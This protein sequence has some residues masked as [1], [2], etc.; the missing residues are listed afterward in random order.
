MISEKQTT[1]LVKS[2]VTLAITGTV[3]MAA[4]AMSTLKSMSFIGKSDKQVSSISVTGEGSSY[5]IPDM[6]SLSFS[7]KAEAK[8]QKKAADEVNVSMKKMIDALKVA[9][10]SEKDIKTNSYNLY[11]QYDWTQQVCP[12]AEA[13]IAVPCTPGKQ[14]LRG[15]EVNQ[16]VEISIKGKENFDNVANFVDV[17]TKN[18][19]TDIGQLQF[20]VEKPEKIQ[21]E[22]REIAIKQAKLKAE[23]LAEQLG[24]ELT[25][26]VGFYEGG[27]SPEYNGR[28]A[29]MNKM[30]MA[31]GAAPTIPVGQN[32]YKANVTITYE[33]E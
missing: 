12:K 32:Q 3:L 31:A 19:A 25:R 5:S 9:G 26:I 20:T 17:V 8:D 1:M 22:A 16:Q 27:Y 13:F 28:S 18:G 2:G 14:V 29:I 4:Y 10:L 33:I 23:K 15:Y 7:I 11:P 6:A 24:V 21:E 30:D